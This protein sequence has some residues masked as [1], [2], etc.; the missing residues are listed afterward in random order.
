M[1]LDPA[2]R[3]GHSPRVR[4]GALFA[5]V[6]GLFLFG[7]DG[8]TAAPDLE[9]ERLIPLPT[10]AEPSGVVFHPSRGTLFVVGDE[11]DL[12]EI[13]VDGVVVQQRRLDR[14]SL[15]GITVDPATGRLYAAFEGDEEIFEFAAEGLQALRR[16]TL[17]RMFAGDT[18]LAAAL[19][20]IE[21]IAFRPD[22]AHPHGGAFFVVNQGVADSPTDGPAVLRVDVP[23]RT[24]GG[25]PA[26]LAAVYP[27]STIDLSGIVHDPATDR[28]LVI[29]DR[30]DVVLEFDLAG[31]LRSTTPLPGDEQE[32]IALDAD[33][34]LYVALESGALLV[35][36]RNR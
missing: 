13:G 26:A 30:A 23:L 20:G 33:G 25:G 12:A 36:N 16:F 8:T 1:T 35:L 9:T 6:L 10:V 17:A 28:L 19:P 5:V 31:R 32:G 7:C 15:E 18:V 27:T 22:A 4:C 34:R 24:P 21:G 2:R 3:P 14:G 29:V 11:G